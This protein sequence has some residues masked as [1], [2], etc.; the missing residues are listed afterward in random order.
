MAAEIGSM[1]VAFRADL[2]AYE[3]SLRKGEKATDR[4]DR[5]A[6]RA[7]DGVGQSFVRMGGLAKAAIGGLVT[8]IVAGGVT[9]A[10]GALR[11]MARGIAEI[12]DEAKRAG[13][14]TKAFQEWAAV[15][16]AAR[17]P[18][19]SLVDGLKE[20]SLRG[21][22]F[23]LSAGKSGSA[24]EA[25]Q[26]L[27]YTS[28]ELATKLKD[29]S[30]LML[31]IIDRLG[32]M[33]RAARIRIADEIFGGA[34]G[35]RFVQLIDQGADGIRK[36]IDE[37]HRLGNV[38]SD[39]VIKD[40]A[41][42][43]RQF[44]LVA[45]TVGNALKRAI[46][47]AAG[48]L[49]QF[50]DSFRAFENQQSASLDA[51]L[52]TIGKQ[53]LDLENKILKLRGE[54]RDAIAGNPFGRDY[55]SDIKFLEEERAALGETE[56][57][58]LRVLEA[59]RKAVEQ[60][61]TPPTTEW[62][63][64]AYTPPASG[65]SSSRDSAAAAADREAEAVRRL[66]SELEHELSLIG[67]TDLQRDISNTLRDAGAA[68]TEEQRAKII[69]LVS[70]LHAEAEASDRAAD[71][72]HA[73]RD[74]G[75]DVLGGIVSDLREGKEAADILANA[76]DR[77]ADR[78]LDMAFDGLFDGLGKGGGGGGFLGS[79]FAGIGKFLGFSRGGFTGHGGRNEPAGIVHRGE[80]VWSQED[81]RRAGGVTV[82][83]SMRKGFASFA[84]GGIVGPMPLAQT[85]SSGRLE[86]VEDVLI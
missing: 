61:T 17:I 85:G 29:P 53:R 14:T 6:K 25:F 50:I 1:Y 35:E 24:A 13:V 9:G 57:Q 34:G 79:L 75:R 36:T 41:E 55:E 7:T 45:T 31:E 48:A 33:D 51:E 44:N 26:R 47:E 11:E 28:E 86:P 15:A 76:L 72:A 67:A 73:L 4:F 83:E 39:E 27:G 74:I 12:G 60:V 81:V 8:G 52:A 46:V 16:K 32:K 62:R 2:A 5:N 43:D 23:V 19:D 49:Q 59:R 78:L 65:G 68:A 66:I 64:P 30:A 20:L 54:Q 40:A 38:L 82:V 18:V 56:A 84:S 10:V 22:E 69:A 63:P 77:V 70:A 71:A 37:A 21:D 80:V 42:L 58:I 3:A